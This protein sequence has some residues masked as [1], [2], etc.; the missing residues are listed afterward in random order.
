[1]S[2]DSLA[3]LVTVQRDRYGR[4]LIP[5]PVTGKQR[6]WTRATTVASTL[7]D[8]F[9]L[10]QWAQRMT[11]RGFVLRP[12]LFALACACDPDDKKK[13]NAVVE[14]AKEAAASSSGANLGTALHS[15]TEQLDRGEV[16]RAPAPWDADLVAYATTLKQAGV[17]IDRAYVENIVTLPDEGVAGTFDRLVNIDGT[18]TVAD[19]KTG[20][21]LDWHEISIQLALYAHASTIYDPATGKHTH[22]PPVDME[23]ALVIHLPA[24]KATCELWMVDIAQGWEA[25]QDALRVRAWRTR[26]GLADKLKTDR[27]R[28]VVA[29]HGL[30]DAQTA[31]LRGRVQR[32]VATLDGKA[33]P[34]PWPTGV[35]T[36]KQGG[37]VD[38]AQCDALG[39]WCDL[40]DA[41]LQLPFPDDAPHQSEFHHATRSM[42]KTERSAFVAAAGIDLVAIPSGLTATD[43]ARILGHNNSSIQEKE[44]TTR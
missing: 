40:V 24:G 9:G 13:L 7:S 21:F 34:A 32:I 15:F 6:A 25:A 36:F 42:T 19:L 41:E 18:L 37:P 11:A 33:L 16:V 29:P 35:P 30:L 23:R 5:D 43:V 8:K 10:Q 44:T 20:S 14:D 3:P 12:D 28:P 4:Y 17:L 39:V 22:M 38:L 2:I 27:Q 31:W 26:K 1:M